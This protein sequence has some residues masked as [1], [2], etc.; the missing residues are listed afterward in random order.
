MN[1][2]RLFV[3]A[4]TAV[5]IGAAAIAWWL[6]S[7][8]FID[9][10][11]DEAFAFDL[12]SEDEMAEMSEDELAE[13]EADFEAAIP[14]EGT[15]S[16]LAEPDR[17][18]VQ[19]RVMAA[20]AAM[21]GHDMDESMPADAGPTA[22]LQ[23][24]FT[25]ADD[26]HRGAGDATI[27]RIPAGGYVLRLENFSVTNGPALSVLLSP[28]S[29][30]RS[31][32]DLGDYVDVGALKGNIGNQNYEIAAIHDVT[33]FKSVVIYCVPFHVIFATADL[34]QP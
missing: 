14:S 25:G 22:V 17:R 31:S 15:L 20:A 2:R 28:A 21:P 4:G 10:V 30:P 24:E 34:A 32:D 5:A 26:F 6:V 9:T 8:L 18:A 1:R 7:P 11:V 29:S 27:F 23:G 13:L 19:E 33:R 12:P 3:L 16:K